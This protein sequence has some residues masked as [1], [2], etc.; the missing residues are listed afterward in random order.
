MLNQPQMS[1]SP[2]ESDTIAQGYF[3]QVTSSLVD[4]LAEI[5]AGLRAVDARLDAL[6]PPHTGRIRLMWVARGKAR[7]YEGEKTPQAVR[8][9]RNRLTGIWSAKRLPIDGLTARAKTSGEFE[10]TS[11]QVRAELANMQLL[12]ELYKQT[13]GR[14]AK[15]DGDW[16]KAH[17]QVT[18]RVRRIATPGGQFLPAKI[19]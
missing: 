8:W 2:P 14:F 12:L 1:P 5:E 11:P 7:G 13:R 15:F 4:C 3:T 16:A 18:R 6:Q 19:D 10:L 17:P 9:S